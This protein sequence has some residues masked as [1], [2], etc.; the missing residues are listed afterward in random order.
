MLKR[1]HHSHTGCTESTSTGHGIDTQEVRLV[2]MLQK[3]T[4]AKGKKQCVGGK[5]WCS[6]CVCVFVKE[7]KKEC[8]VG[9]VSFGLLQ[10]VIIVL[11]LVCVI[12]LEFVC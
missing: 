8:R 9:K 7:G 10:F 12:Q 4:E 2:A 11:L 3:T 5:T 6:R 1:N